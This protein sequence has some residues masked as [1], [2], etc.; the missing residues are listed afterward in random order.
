MK[1]PLAI[2]LLA[3][4]GAPAGAQTV[5]KCSADGKV[6]YGA[7]PCASGKSVELNV[8]PAP[9]PS[10]ADAATLARHKKTADRLEADRLRREA[11]EDREQARAAQAGAARRKKCAALALQHKWAVEDA[12]AASDRQADKAK[13]KARRSAEKLALECPA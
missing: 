1:R 3:A 12:R 9:Q 7:A 2:L 10:S 4:L 13:V 5:Y 8:A 6:S 11:Q